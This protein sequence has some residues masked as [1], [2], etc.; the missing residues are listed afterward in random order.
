MDILLKDTLTNLLDLE[1]HAAQAE[2]VPWQGREA[3]RLENGLA[4]V[5][6]RRTTD[7]SIEVPIGADGPAYPG[8]AFRVADVLNFELASLHLTSVASGMRCSTTRFSTDRI[9]GRCITARA[10]NAPRRCQPG[11]ASG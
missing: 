9:P 3:L 11:A 5:P 7:A 8:V 6:G 10:T 2:V 4:L 1:I